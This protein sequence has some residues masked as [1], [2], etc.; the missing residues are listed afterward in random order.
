VAR[1]EDRHLRPDAR[2]RDVVSVHLEDAQFV[3]RPINRI[4]RPINEFTS[5][6][7]PNINGNSA[8]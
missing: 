7:Q 1:D 5:L 4:F 3:T 2:A 8:A 6:H